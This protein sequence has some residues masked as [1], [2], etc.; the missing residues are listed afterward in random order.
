MDVNLFLFFLS[1]F[2]VFVLHLA[3]FAIVKT[4]VRAIRMM[5]SLAIVLMVFPV[6]YV[7]FA[8]WIVVQTHRKIPSM[9]RVHANARKVFL[10]TIAK[11]QEIRVSKEKNQFFADHQIKLSSACYF[12]SCIFWRCDVCDCTKE[13]W[14]TITKIK[15]K[16]SPETAL[17]RLVSSCFFFFF[18]SKKI[19][20][21]K[22]D[23]I[24]GLG[25]K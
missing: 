11:V 3:K 24:F 12:S 22:L 17:K 9:A 14:Q 6:L 7:I 18:R 8:A 21:L 19:S 25:Q 2:S 5:I 15:P 23:M 20:Q 13:R 10:V 16:N 1:S 4:A